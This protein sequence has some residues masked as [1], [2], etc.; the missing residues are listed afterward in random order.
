MARNDDLCFMPATEMAAAIAGRRL[1]P[2]EVIDALLERI[3]RVNPAVN[4]F[5][6]LRAEE[7]RAEARSAEQAVMRGDRLGPLHG[8]PVTIKDL[9]ITKGIK[10]MR[11][12]RAFAD[13]VPDENAVVVDRLLAAGALFLGKTTTPEFGNK[14]TGESP[15]TGETNNPWKLTHCAGGSSSGAA[16]GVAAGM[17]PLALGSD[18]AGSI[19]IPASLCGVPGFKPS[20]GRVP[21]FPPPPFTT[22]AH[23]GPIAR[24]VADCALMLGAMAGVD[25]RDPYSITDPPADYVAPL[26]QASLAGMRIAYSGDLGW[27][28]VARQVRER[29]DAAVKLLAGTLGAAVDEATPALP[30][31]ETPMMNLW[32]AQF[33]TIVEDQLL[34]RVRGPEDLDPS[35]LVFHERA[36]QLTAMDVQRAYLFRSEFYRAMLTF[37]EEYELLVTPTLACPP[38]PHPGWQPGPAQ[39]DGVAIDPFLGWLMT[40][41]FNLTGQP[42]ITVPCGF[43]DDGLPVGL[44]IVGR[45]RQD[46]AVL[47]AAA[48]FERAAPWAHMRPPLP[49]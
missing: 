35:I 39:I 49:E 29:T 33:G 18:G 32:S 47:Q 46:V 26:Q 44:Q 30:N 34:P 41:P 38:F 14:G 17:G 4:A 2:V 37:F 11:G 5:T 31:P 13:Y 20:Y 48:C 25:H 28:K 21:S 24:T 22:L 40:Y 3:E 42:A 23:Q 15:L 36:K 1:S 10:T 45:P 19:R 16:A 9:T 6:V 8:V 27:Y 7:V 43:T 12:S